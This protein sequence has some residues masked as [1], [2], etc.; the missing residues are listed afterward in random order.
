MAREVLP[1]GYDE[2]LGELKERVRKAQLRAALAV[3]SELVRLYWQ[4]GNEIS[5]KMRVEGWGAKNA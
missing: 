4:I 3:N 5:G 2:L 1:A